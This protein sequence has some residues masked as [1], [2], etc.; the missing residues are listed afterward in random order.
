M[1]ELRGN[2]EKA[3]FPD[4][5]PKIQAAPK[6]AR[7]PTCPPHP[8]A[9]LATLQH[10]RKHLPRNYS[11]LLPTG[12]SRKPGRECAQDFSG[13]SDRE[14]RLTDAA[15]R[16]C[17][18]RRL[19]F[20]TGLREPALLL[21][22]RLVPLQL[23]VGLLRAWQAVPAITHS[24]FPL[25]TLHPTKPFNENHRAQGLH[26]RHP[27]VAALIKPSRKP[28]RQR[29]LLVTPAYLSSFYSSCFPS[30]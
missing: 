6:Q 30:S 2:R 26:K 21:W 1:G 28:R 5:H 19:D 11:V 20:V 15:A 23:A 16:L 22:H 3:D 25:A 13:R 18:E 24:C 29:F 7:K 10:S 27:G 17:R 4:S 9:H 8:W 14:T 12:H